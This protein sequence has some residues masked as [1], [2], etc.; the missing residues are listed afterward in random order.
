[1]NFDTDT[2]TSLLGSD[3]SIDGIA[4]GFA[5]GDITFQANSWGDAFNAGEFELTG[6]FF[7]VD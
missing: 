7:D 5:S 2:I 6:T 4:A 1:M 3:S